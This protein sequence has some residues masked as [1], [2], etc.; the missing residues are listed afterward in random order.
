MVKYTTIMA[1]NVQIEKAEEIIIL[2]KFI[3]GFNTISCATQ[4]GILWKLTS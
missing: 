2:F 4:A 3:C 1:G